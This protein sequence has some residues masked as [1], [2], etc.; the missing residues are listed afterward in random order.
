MNKEET[1]TWSRTPK[2]LTSRLSKG[3]VS[4]QTAGGNGAKATL[5][6]HEGSGVSVRA[7]QLRLELHTLPV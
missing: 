2:T 3:R 4:A 5:A 6:S 1:N 7:K